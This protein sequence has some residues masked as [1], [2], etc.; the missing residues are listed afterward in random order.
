MLRRA[1]A[2]AD[3]KGGKWGII[4]QQQQNQTARSKTGATAPTSNAETTIR[5]RVLSAIN[6]GAAP[7]DLRDC[8]STMTIRV[9]FQVRPRVPLE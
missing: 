1:A 6:P 3:A 4:Q 9:H 5:Q 8:G 7:L 2:P